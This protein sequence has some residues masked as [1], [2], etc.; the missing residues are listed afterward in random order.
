MNR[1]NVLILSALAAACFASAA[2]ASP[3]DPTKDKLAKKKSCCAPSVVTV[4]SSTPA[5]TL[6]LS[7]RSAGSANTAPIATV[8]ANPRGETTVVV[9]GV[10]C[11][12][13]AV[14]VTGAPT[15][16]VAGSF[17]T[18]AS[19]PSAVAITSS[20][21]ASVAFA[22]GTTAC[23]PSAV[24]VACDPKKGSQ[25]AHGVASTR[26]LAPNGR[27]HAAIATRPALRAEC[28]P[29]APA[30]P[31]EAAEPCAP[32]AP[33][34]PAV[35]AKPSKRALRADVGLAP[36]S[37]SH[38]VLTQAP[39]STTPGAMA[40]LRELVASVRGTVDAPMPALQALAEI[41]VPDLELDT[42]ELPDMGDAVELE[43]LPEAQRVEIR[44][45]TRK[46]LEEARAQVARA[47]DE[48]RGQMD[49]VRA[50]MDAAR[51][52]GERDMDD[53]HESIARAHELYARARAGQLEREHEMLPRKLAEGERQKAVER[54]LAAREAARAHDEDADDDSSEGQDENAPFGKRWKRA[55]EEGARGW[56]QAFGGQAGSDAKLEARVDALEEIARERGF[57][58]DENGSLED[59]VAELERHLRGAP[60][61]PRAKRST[62]WTAPRVP[63]T[64][65]VPGVHGKPRV[66]EIPR[67]P[68]GLA[69]GAW[70]M[71][72]DGKLRP[73]TK[74]EAEI[75]LPKK[76]DHGGNGVDF[77]APKHGQGGHD[78][79]FLGAKLGKQKAERKS[80]QHGA[81]REAL[82]ERLQSLRDEANELREQM[83][84][85]REELRD[86]SEGEGR[87]K[88]P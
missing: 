80:A 62:E 76:P 61:A 2:H 70:R 21:K 12:A 77:F 9:N 46:A 59:R 32:A 55:M 14:T 5:G 18:T 1:T 10:A 42:I 47:R 29:A 16:E 44:E 52:E 67:L 71:G 64:P 40:D 34:P 86:A 7:T 23:A 4:P 26:A 65:K 3:C 13:P 84:E 54:A 11:V 72:E 48:I 69:P 49:K 20:P 81:T 25:A 53:H 28:A 50:E 39:A 6:T 68:A 33:C 37:S 31:A 27:S 17:A 83:S 36:S 43:S 38:D 41:D 8:V 57:A 60:S 30:A 82:E 79:F 35:P 45:T 58:L 51:A 19:A 63:S 87:S 78:D 88:R 22:S 24:A 74:G 56:A 85:L 15:A 66:I 73:L 75:Y